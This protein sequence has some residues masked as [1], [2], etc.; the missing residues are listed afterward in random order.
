MSRPKNVIQQVS[1][2][3]T[4]DIATYTKM[5]LFLWQE[6]AGGKVPQSAI[7]RLITMLINKFFENRQGVRELTDRK[8]VERIYDLCSTIRDLASH[9]KAVPAEALPA[10]GA[11]AQEACS[12][13]INKLK[14]LS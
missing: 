11:F 4:L 14:E 1:L 8:D 9:P 3:T 13:L 6:S 2:H 5:Q 12:L 10:V 7:K